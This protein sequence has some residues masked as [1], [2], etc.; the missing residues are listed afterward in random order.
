MLG[1]IQWQGNGGSSYTVG[2]V[3]N[4]PL[5]A[6]ADAEDQKPTAG[7]ALLTGATGNRNCISNKRQ[8]F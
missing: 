7:N 6:G 4:H 5:Q 1:R 3:G 2:K 8:R